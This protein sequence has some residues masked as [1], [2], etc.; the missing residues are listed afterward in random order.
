LR[1]QLEA[2]GLQD[3]ARLAVLRF[4][5]GA[6]ISALDDETLPPRELYVDLRAVPV[7][8]ASKDGC[9]RQTRL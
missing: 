2:G 6:L 4:F 5:A 8:T 3:R 9:K 7:V 1:T